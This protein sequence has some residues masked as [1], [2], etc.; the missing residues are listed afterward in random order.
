MHIPRLYRWGINVV[1]STFWTVGGKLVVDGSGKLILCAT[2]PCPGD[3]TVSLPCC[4]SFAVCCDASVRI[5]KALFA[6]VNVR[7]GPGPGGTILDTYS[8]PINYT[9]T[10]NFGG[11]TKTGWYGCATRDITT[12]CF[13]QGVVFLQCAS[14]EFRITFNGLIP[15]GHTACD[16]YI[17]LFGAA[18]SLDGTGG[19]FNL[20]CAPFSIATEFDYYAASPSCG[21]IYIEVAISE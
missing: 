17:A 10:A 18:G 1:S 21:A 6:T 4:D 11:S 16:G 12:Q 19:S 14:G 8:V 15:G 7:Q 20:V 2:C 13:G 9:T 3:E 5:K